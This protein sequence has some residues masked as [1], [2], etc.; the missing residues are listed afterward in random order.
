LK[1][2]LWHQQKAAKRKR[3]A[4]I[5]AGIIIFAAF[6]SIVQI[7]IKPIIY[8]I[9]SQKAHLEVIKIINEAIDDQ[10]GQGIGYQQLVNVVTNEN[11][12]V[13]YIQ[14]DTIKITR[15]TTA[16]GKDIEV[17]INNLEEQGIDFPIGLM[18][19]YILL[20]DKGP[21]FHIDIKPTGDVSVDI[22]DEFVEAGINQ[23]KHRVILNVTTE[24]GILIPF[25]ADLVKVSNSLPLAE[26]IIVGPIPETYLNFNDTDNTENKTIPQITGD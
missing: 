19:G 9:A 11:G 1:N 12:T 17:R 21:N 23:T 14:P 25:S 3:K 26:N 7:Q 16:I 22:T 4:K 6:L 15:L 2:K 18:T 8:T 13:S 5:I 10:M 24:L 20:A